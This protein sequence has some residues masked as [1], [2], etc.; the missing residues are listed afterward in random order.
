MLALAARQA[1]GRM[2]SSWRPTQSQQ[3]V[4]A[5]GRRRTSRRL[6]IMERLYVAAVGHKVSGER[7]GDQANAVSRMELLAALHDPCTGAGAHLARA[8]NAAAPPTLASP[9][10]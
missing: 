7:A 8:R 3:S 9:L 4:D 1:C 5:G 10:T 2:R 6:A